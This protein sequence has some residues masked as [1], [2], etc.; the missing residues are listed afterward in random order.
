MY[1]DFFY[2]YVICNGVDEEST[3][4]HAANVSQ[5]TSP[6]SNLKDEKKKKMP[7]I[8]L[9]IDEIPHELEDLHQTA[10]INASEKGEIAGKSIMEYPVELRI[11]EI[12][13]QLRFQVLHDMGISRKEYAQLLGNP[14]IPK[15]KL[16][17]LEEEIEAEVEQWYQEYLEHREKLHRVTGRPVFGEAEQKALKD[18]VDRICYLRNLVVEI[19]MLM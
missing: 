11:A 8:L 9:A 1:D 17:K 12:K 2:R 19:A 16:A 3:A 10:H 4:M 14:D 13:A 5:N 18:K 6:A 15:E 7:S